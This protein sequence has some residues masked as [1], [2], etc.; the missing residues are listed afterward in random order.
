MKVEVGALTDVG[1]KRDINQ[2]AILVD[3]DLGLYVVADGMGGHRGGEVASAMA[4]ETIRDYFRRHGGE[5]SADPRF[6]IQAA[7]SEASAK[8]HHKSTVE[9]TE[10]MGMGTTM[11]A[12]LIRGK[13]AFIANVG[14]SR[15]YLIRHPHIW[16]VT[17]DH[18][19]INEQVKMGA[20]S[21]EEAPKIIARNVITR[22]VGFERDVL[23]DIQEREILPGD[24]FLLCSDGL[25]GLVKDQRLA[26]IVSK[27]N[28]KEAAEKCI[29]EAKKGGGDDNISVAIIRPIEN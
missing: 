29:A 3:H 26:E 27:F 23:V 8:I 1:L 28:T 18:S 20:I 4:V 10:L 15:A 9:A 5:K 22:S 12:L 11:V 6:M 7:Y 21:E 16:Q 25:S 14:D 24:T 19:L 17:E 13:K 2:D